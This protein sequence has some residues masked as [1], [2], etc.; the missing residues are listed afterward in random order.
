MSAFKDKFSYFFRLGNK[1]TEWAEIENLT[2]D[3]T[4]SLR[5]K[6]LIWG[7]VYILIQ[8][9]NASVKQLFVLE[10]DPA[11]TSELLGWITLA[12]TLYY[13]VQ[14]SK[15]IWGD[16][17]SFQIQSLGD[18]I[19]DLNDSLQEV[20]TEF[21]G[22]GR[23][24]DQD[25]EKHGDTLEKAISSYKKSVKSLKRKSSIRNALFWLFDILPVLG[26]LLGCFWYMLA[27]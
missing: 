6:S 23:H 7:A 10:F 11:L 5:D 25:E 22:L 26:V 15:N 9:Q 18:P 24:F 3:K 17:A 4:D 19:S 14:W 20:I 21:N 8:A 27:E 12:L 2:S 1:V 13:S 16:V